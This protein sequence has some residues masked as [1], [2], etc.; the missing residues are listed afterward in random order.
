MRRLPT[1]SQLHRAF[2]CAASEALPH[3]QSTSEDA[4]RGTMVHAFIE[5][6]RK[7]GRDEALSD[8]PPDYDGYEFCA[9]LPLNLLPAG[10]THE[11]ALAWDHEA[12]TARAL[13]STGHRDYEEAK[14]TEFVGTAD[15][16][17]REGAAV[18]VLDYK[19]GHK[20]LGPA[21]ESRQLRMLALAAARVEGVDEAR[22]GYCFLR[23]D[24][25]Y[26]FSWA[27][28]DAFDLA[29]I[30]DELRDLVATLDDAQTAADVRDAR[31]FHEG[32]WCDY[33]PAFNS[34]PAKMQL[35][36]A[37]GT[38][39]ALKEL[40]T[41]ERRIEQMTDAELARAYEAIERYDDVAERVRK[42][43][44]ARAAMQPIELGEGRRLG[45]VPWPFTSIKPEVAY[46]TVRELHGEAAAEAAVPRRATLG[47]LKKLGD[48]T[49]AEVE[50][51][52]G[53]VTGSKPQVRVHRP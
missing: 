52:R 35:A 43:V 16:V 14:P 5:H 42:A 2:R 18:V 19:T 41:I 1:A 6:A 48:E 12:D 9:A 33:C 10:G 15:Y 37:I 26:S 32:E 13:P 39:D 24:G 7:V 29:A 34:C 44:R 49:V 40:A 46:A 4:E 51:R 8:L 21:R 25:T 22:A 17:G 30:A 23:E 27:E 31:D 36:R 50:R 38:G 53:V 3:F 45:A 28:F 20:Y 47:A 11:L